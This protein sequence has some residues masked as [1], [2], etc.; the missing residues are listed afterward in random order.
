MSLFTVC[1]RR[2]VAPTNQASHELILSPAASAFLFRNRTDRVALLLRR[3]FST[4]TNLPQ[5]LTATTIPQVAP[6]RSDLLEL[7]RRAICIINILSRSLASAPLSRRTSDLEQPTRLSYRRFESQ[8]PFSNCPL[9]Y[10]PTLPS[11]CSSLLKQAL[12]PELQP[13]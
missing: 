6:F 13:T 7:R 8:Y 1:G 12:R 10:S 3:I 4:P 9:L 11:S 2:A 5:R